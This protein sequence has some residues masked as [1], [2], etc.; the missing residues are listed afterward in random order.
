MLVLFKLS[1]GMFSSEENN[2]N[3]FK[4]FS[5]VTLLLMEL[6]KSGPVFYEV[7]VFFGLILHVCNIL[8]LFNYAFF[9]VSSFHLH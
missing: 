2:T 7:K 4:G 6:T 5:A 3:D 8:L 9:T 1:D